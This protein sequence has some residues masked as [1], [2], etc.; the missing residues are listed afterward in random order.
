[1]TFDRKMKP[2]IEASPTARVVLAANNRPRFSDRSGGLWRRMVVLPW[3]VRVPESEQVHGMDKPDWWQASGEL[4]GIFCWAVAGMHRL[5]LQGRF[6]VPQVCKEALAEYRTE[7][8]PARMFLEEHYVEDMQSWTATGSV[9]SAY[10]VVRRERLHALAERTFGRECFR[11]SRRRNV[12]SGQRMGKVLGIP[13]HSCVPV[14]SPSEPSSPSIPISITG[15]GL[16]VEVGVR[17]RSTG[18]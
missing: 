18:L 15:G 17:R 4:P 14:E 12:N 5:R 8:N 1:M 3:R 2:A 10:A 11:P 16:N 9:Y 7:S 6:T 13:R